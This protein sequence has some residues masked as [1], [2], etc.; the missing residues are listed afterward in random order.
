MMKYNS[1]N[2]I[3]LRFV[4]IGPENDIWSQIAIDLLDKEEQFAILFL[5]RKTRLGVSVCY[6][7]TGPILE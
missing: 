5:Y 4:W 3:L 1:Q 2:K 6:M 7:G